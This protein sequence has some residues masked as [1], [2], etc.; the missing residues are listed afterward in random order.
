LEPMASIFLAGGSLHMG[1]G[2]VLTNPPG[3]TFAFTDDSAVFSDGGSPV[4]LNQGTVDKTGGGN[5]IGGIGP[6]SSRIDVP[7][8][9]H[10]VARAS[11]GTLQI[12][13]GGLTGSSLDTAAG[14]RVL[15]SSDYTLNGATWTGAGTGQV[16]GGITTLTNDVT[17]AVSN[18]LHSGGT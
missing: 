7:F 4:F 15:L 1:T 11:V 16:S 17:V 10:S 2:A 6:N 12:A 14:A 3:V 9:N 5:G 18:F 13:G 8:F